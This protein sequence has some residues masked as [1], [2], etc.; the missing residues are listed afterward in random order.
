MTFNYKTRIQKYDSDKNIIG[1]KFVVLNKKIIFTRN[2]LMDDIPPIYILFTV[3]GSY[4]V[5]IK[6][7]SDK[8]NFTFF[9]EIMNTID[10]NIY[11]NLSKTNDYSGIFMP[12][13]SSYFGIS[14]TL[15]TPQIENGGGLKKY[16]MDDEEME[17]GYPNY[18]RYPNY[19]QY[20]MRNAIQMVKK[21]ENKD[22]VQLS[23]YITIDMEL[24]PGT[25]LTPEEM[26]NYKCNQK[27]NTVRKAYADFTGKPY[28]IPPVYPTKTE[29]NNKS[30][31]NNTRKN[32]R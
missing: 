7:S 31:Q 23:Y 4:Y 28:I 20:P 32:R 27:W 3:F 11:Y 12:I 9:P 19:N 5:K 22:E 1:S 25:S 10:S 14:K 6:N 16:I 8:K 15:T 13:F 21:E 29:K 2:D 30:Q 18:N 26:K 17:G 24:H